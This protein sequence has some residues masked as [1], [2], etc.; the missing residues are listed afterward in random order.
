MTGKRQMPIGCFRPADLP[1]PHRLLVAGPKFVDDLT[2]RPVRR[3][4]PQWCAVGAEHRH[5]LRAEALFRQGSECGQQ[6]DVRIAILV[7][8]YPVG[9]HALG[10]QM[11]AD[12]LAHQGDVL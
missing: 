4:D 3:D 10:S 11:V 8:I 2:L 12:E 7:V 9:D 6:V 1:A 5:F